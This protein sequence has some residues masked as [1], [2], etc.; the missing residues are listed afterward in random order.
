MRCR[1]CGAEIPN[2]SIYCDKC[3]AEFVIVPD[4]NPLDEFL[5]ENIRESIYDNRTEEEKQE[6]AQ[7]KRSRIRRKK[8][9]EQMKQARIRQRRN[10]LIMSGVT[11]ATGMIIIFSSVTS[12]DAKVKKGYSAF[13]EKQYTVAENMFQ[14][15]ISKKENRADAYIGLSKVYAA[16]DKEK[17]AE[18]MFLSAIEKYSLEPELYRGLFEFYMDTEQKGKIPELLE[19]CENKELIDQLKEYISKEPVFSLEKEEYDDVQELQLKSKGKTIYYTIDGSDVT[20]ESK[21][22]TKPIH[23]A[24]GT[25][26]VKAMAVNK[27][28]VPSLVKE[29]TYTIEFPMI[30]APAVTPSTG[31]YDKSTKI[32]VKVP[33]GYTAYYT[34]DGSKPDRDSNQYEEPIDMPEGKAVFSVI[35]IDDRGR[36]SDVTKRHYDLSL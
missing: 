7:W 6:E 25:T 17:E 4:Y 10:R 1:N 20:T 18:K 23:L 26:I 8:Q 34:M 16:Q 11:V 5:T 14:K 9:R 28:G 19:L 35:L 2:H 21:K 22:Y 32:T 36:V 29:K 15:A 31:Q 13:N 27:K 12:Y 33:D 30:D 3:G 24:E